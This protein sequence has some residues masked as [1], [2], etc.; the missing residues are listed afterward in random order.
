M[1]TSRGKPSFSELMAKNGFDPRGEHPDIKPVAAPVYLGRGEWS[2]PD[3]PYSPE[4]DQGYG[5]EESEDLS[6]MDGQ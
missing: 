4:D 6:W 2:R 3:R 1:S 5:P